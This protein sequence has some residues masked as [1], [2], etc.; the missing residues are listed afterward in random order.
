MKW[1]GRECTG[2]GKEEE[3]EEEG[4]EGEGD[5]RRLR[6]RRNVVVIRWQLEVGWIVA[7]FTCC[8]R[9]LHFSFR[10]DWVVTI[11]LLTSP[12][13][14]ALTYTLLHHCQ[15]C[16]IYLHIFFR[17]ARVA[18]LLPLHFSFGIVTIVM[19]P[20]SLQVAE[21]LLPHVFCIAG[22]ATL[23]LLWLRFRMARLAIDYNSALLPL[24][25]LEVNRTSNEIHL[26]LQK[27]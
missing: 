4:G 27:C 11:P 6:R 14:F 16:R 17:I 15:S 9:S 5:R 3:D 23:S 10:I 12:P 22:I 18:T 19:R 13:L 21:L 7:F 25:S 24:Y 26:L 8:F 20:P 1:G 2:R